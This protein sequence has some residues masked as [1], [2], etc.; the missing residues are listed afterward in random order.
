MS[1]DGILISRKVSLRPFEPADDIRQ[2]HEWYGQFFA[3]MPWYIDRSWLNEDDFQAEFQATERSRLHIRMMIEY[4]GYGVGTICS[5]DYNPSDGWVY[6]SIFM[7]PKVQGRLGIGQL[8][9]ALFVNRLFGNYSSLRR[10]Y[11][12]V[13]GYDLEYAGAFQRNNFDPVAV[14]PDHT[15]WDGGYCDQLLFMIG[16][17]RYKHIRAYIHVRRQGL[18]LATA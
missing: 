18:E 17:E 8:S 10:I 12:A 2:L 4:D 14:I 6:V 1:D 3:F 9:F 15:L 16:R 13:P 11:C 7:D 5:Y